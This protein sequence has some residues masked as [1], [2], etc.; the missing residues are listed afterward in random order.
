MQGHDS[1]TETAALAN[2]HGTFNLECL[3]IGPSLDCDIEFSSVFQFDFE[4]VERCADSM[5]SFL[6][7]QYVYSDSL[8]ECTAFLSWIRDESYSP[9]PAPTTPP[10]TEPTTPDPDAGSIRCVSSAF[11]AGHWALLATDMQRCSAEVEYW[12][13]ALGTTTFSCTDQVFQDDFHTVYAGE[14]CIDEDDDDAS[15]RE[16]LC[17]D[18]PAGENWLG[19]S[20]CFTTCHPDYWEEITGYDS[21]VDSVQ[22]ADAAGGSFELR[23][24]TFGPSFGTCSAANFLTLDGISDCV[25]SMHSV[26]S[27]QYVYTDSEEQCNGFLEFMRNRTA[28]PTVPSLAPSTS[29]PTNSAPTP[30]PAEPDDGRIR[31]IESPTTA[32][33]YALFATNEQAC[34]HEVAHW[35]AALG[36]GLSLDST[37]MA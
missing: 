37:A 27:H 29:A 4:S 34:D 5:P 35:N 20:Q 26:L 17:A 15:L 33:Q 1:C 18:C 7:H 36:A 23:C 28:S 2:Q 14:R 10:P 9:T 30:V 11:T 31:C 25:R 16:C 12:N 13:A 8:E 32:G 24:L 19:L 21:C 22:T 6:S 3:G